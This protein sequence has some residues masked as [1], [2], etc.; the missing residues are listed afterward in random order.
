[1]AGGRR[2]S[3]KRRDG[4]CCGHRAAEYGHLLRQS[5]GP[6]G[7]RLIGQDTAR[8]CSRRFWCEVLR[9]DAEAH[10]GSGDASSLWHLVA[11]V[12]HHH[13]RKAVGGSGMRGGYPSVVDDGGEMGKHGGIVDPI[14]H[15]TA[16]RRPC[17]QPGKQLGR[18][19]P[20]HEQRGSTGIVERSSRPPEEDL[21]IAERRAKG[22][23]NYGAAG[24]G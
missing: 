8:K 21:V 7:Q 22:D 11:G 2:P 23:Q 20:D 3:A 19:S 13:L 9:A 6:G 24:K 5:P 1:M 15:R 12:R 18:S 10:A 14:G 16:G 4:R 17:R